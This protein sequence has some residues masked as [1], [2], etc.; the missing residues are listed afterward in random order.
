MTSALSSS[1]TTTSQ[2]QASSRGVTRNWLWITSVF[3]AIAGIIDT[4][5]LVW[6]KLANAEVYCPPGNAFSCDLVQSS[7]YSRIGPIPIQY[8]GLVGYLAILGVLLLEPRVPFFAKRGKLLVFGM[9]L[10]GFLYSAYLTAIEAFVLQ[11]WCLY[12]L[13][14]AIIMTMLFVVAFIRIWRS[15]SA[16]TADGVDSMAAEVEA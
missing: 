8:I 6:T 5:Y 11:A 7:I 10:F 16:D 2:T 14:S 15:F 12:C 3:L 9:T 4:G 1:S 13:I